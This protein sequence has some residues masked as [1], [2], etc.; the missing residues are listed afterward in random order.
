MN[1]PKCFSFRA[2]SR[3]GPKAPI[4]QMTIIMSA[5]TFKKCFVDAISKTKGQ[6]Y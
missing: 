4:K 5:K 3:L 2:Q 6:I 1:L